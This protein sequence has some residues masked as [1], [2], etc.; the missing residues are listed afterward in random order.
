M[1]RE[2]E[3]A[4]MLKAVGLLKRSIVTGNRNASLAC[5]CEGKRLPMLNQVNFRIRV[6]RLAFVTSKK[7]LYC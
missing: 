2:W 1:G 4:G 7:A 3:E 5:E 6:G